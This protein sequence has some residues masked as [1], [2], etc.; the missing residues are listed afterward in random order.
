MQRTV[1]VQLGCVVER[2]RVSTLIEHPSSID[3]AEIT[4]WHRANP[5]AEY[6]QV[7]IASGG[8]SWEFAAAFR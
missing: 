3:P 5:L 8:W 1:Q 2:Q 4:A 6:P 7:D